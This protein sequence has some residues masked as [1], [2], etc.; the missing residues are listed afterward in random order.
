M[1]STWFAACVAASGLRPCIGLRVRFVAISI[2]LYPLILPI[3]FFS[4]KR[5]DRHVEESLRRVSVNVNSERSSSSLTIFT[6]DD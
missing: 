1:A 3:F 6:M 5:K 4:I 2:E